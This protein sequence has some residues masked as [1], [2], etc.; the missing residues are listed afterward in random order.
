M[1]NKPLGPNAKAAIG[2]IIGAT[3][4]LTNGDVNDKESRKGYGKTIAELPTF[5]AARRFLAAE[6]RRFAAILDV[7]SGER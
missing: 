2:G 7:S 5:G 4:A 6:L 1:N 3:I